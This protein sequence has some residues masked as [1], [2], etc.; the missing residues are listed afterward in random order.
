MRRRAR[1][2]SSYAPVGRGEAVETT[3]RWPLRLS[4][5]EFGLEG[6]RQSVLMD[7]L[8]GLHHGHAWRSPCRT[9]GLSYSRFRSARNALEGRAR[10]GD[11]RIAERAPCGARALAP[12]AFR[13]TCS[14]ACRAARGRC[15]GIVHSPSSRAILRAVG[16]DPD[17]DLGHRGVT[18][19]LMI[20]RD[21]RV[22]TAYRSPRPCGV[23]S[24]VFLLRAALPDARYQSRQG[25]CD[26][27]RP[28]PPPPPPRPGTRSW[29]ISPM[30]HPPKA[31]VLVGATAF[32]PACVQKY[33]PDVARSMRALG[34][35]GSRERRAFQR[36]LPPS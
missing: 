28:P 9:C 13:R 14:S 18:T 19:R 1:D 2:G 10:A 31:T 17:H 23:G 12:V 33:L 27:S 6:G 15:A 32:A 30:G 3:Q 36:R 22:T 4:C 11:R 29:R 7:V 8:E 25:K 16:L 35:R 34:R 26:G 21:G 5:F 24:R 20:A